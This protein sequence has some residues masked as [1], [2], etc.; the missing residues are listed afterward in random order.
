MLLSGGLV[1]S[2]YLIKTKPS[3]GTVRSP[4]AKSKTSLYLSD[5]GSPI[6]KKTSSVS[7]SS[8]SSS[9]LRL[10]KSKQMRIET[11]K[12]IGLRNSK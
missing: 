7:R 8:F 9:K 12:K 1:H 11:T 10:S 3:F 6:K 4:A 5:F 2:E